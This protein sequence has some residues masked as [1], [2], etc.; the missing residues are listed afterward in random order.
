MS[1]ACPPRHSPLF[2]TSTTFSNNKS[3]F[4]EMSTL[5]SVFPHCTLPDYLSIV[6]H[7]LQLSSLCPIGN[8]I[9]YFRK[10]HKHSVYITTMFIKQHIVALKINRYLLKNMFTIY[11]CNNLAG[12]CIIIEHYTI[13]FSTG[14]WTQCFHLESLCQPFYVMGFFKRRSQGTVYQGGFE[15]EIFLISA[16]WVAGIT[17]VSHWCAANF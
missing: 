2:C 5:I 13:F 6:F 9:S 14:V 15:T 1:H 12:Q 4:F 11:I 17:E 16:S 7:L 3:P 10:K 8:G